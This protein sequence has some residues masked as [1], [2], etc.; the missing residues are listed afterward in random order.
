MGGNSNFYACL[1]SD[2][3]RVSLR[4]A[5]YHN[6]HITLRLRLCHYKHHFVS[7]DSLALAMRGTYGRWSRTMSDPLM[8]FPTMYGV[9]GGRVARLI[10]KQ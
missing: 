8:E 2:T 1:S 10:Y 9:H 7:D 3:D 6:G 5:S 4:W